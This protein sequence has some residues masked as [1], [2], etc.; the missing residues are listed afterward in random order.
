MNKFVL[1]LVSLLVS[2]FLFPNFYNGKVLAQYSPYDSEYS[3]EYS[4]DSESPSEGSEESSECSSEEESEESSECCSECN[5]EDSSAE[6]ACGCPEWDGVDCDDDSEDSEECSSEDE[7]ISDL[8]LSEC[9][10]EDTGDSG[11][12]T[13][14]AA[15]AD[16]GGGSGSG[17]MGSPAWCEKKKIDITKDDKG[18]V[19]AVTKR[20]KRWE[21][22]TGN[23]TLGFGAVSGSYTDMKVCPPKEKKLWGIGFCLSF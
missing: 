12:D 17:P 8:G 10:S 14:T 23:T 7:D 4:Y 3:S 13:V 15:P 22:C 2:W 16:E 6:N 11:D 5:D 19:C 20:I 18:S 21:K 9:E 1:V